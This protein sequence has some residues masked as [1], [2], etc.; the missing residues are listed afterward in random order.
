MCFKIQNRILYCYNFLRVIYLGVFKIQQSAFFELQVNFPK[1]K[2]LADGIAY[3]R[4]F[5]GI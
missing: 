5:G 2:L 4:L 3:I 1:L